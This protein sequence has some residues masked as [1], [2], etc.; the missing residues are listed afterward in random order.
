MNT[1]EP[2]PVSLYCELKETYLE[3]DWIHYQLL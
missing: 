2:C 3:W 1:I